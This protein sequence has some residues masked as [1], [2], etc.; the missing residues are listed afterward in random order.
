MLFTR[1]PAGIQTRYFDMPQDM[2]LRH[3]ISSAL[4]FASGVT[5]I[6]AINDH[7]HPHCNFQ[8]PNLLTCLAIMSSGKF[9]V[10][11]DYLSPFF[12]LVFYAISKGLTPEDSMK[13]TSPSCMVASHRGPVMTPA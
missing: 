4:D 6:A 9:H 12:L 3:L 2:R 13:S 11:Q 8:L 7:H 10:R 5:E 1:G